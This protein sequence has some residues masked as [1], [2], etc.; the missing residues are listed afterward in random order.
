M[1]RNK[2]DPIDLVALILFPF[3]GAAALGVVDF[4]VNLTESFSFTDVLWSGTGWSVT[5]AG[6]IA[7]VGIAWI[8]GTNH[9]DGKK[10]FWQKMDGMYAG[11]VLIAFAVVPAYMFIAPVSEFL[12][13]QPLVAFGM[14]LAQTG[15]AAVVSYKG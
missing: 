14:A 7:L 4:S 13:A 15:A 1:A 3:F 8:F 12:D 9:M 5:I 6:A 2:I 10:A 11:A